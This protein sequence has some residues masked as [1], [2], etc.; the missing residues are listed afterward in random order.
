MHEISV[1]AHRRLSQTGL[2]QTTL[3]TLV[4]HQNIAHSMSDILTQHSPLFIKSYG[5]ATEST[6]EFRGTS[7]S[8]TQVLW[9][10]LRINSPMLGTVDF[11]TIPAFFIDQANL[12]HGASSLTLTGG[13]LGGAV[14][15]STQPTD[16]AGLGLQYIQGVGSFKT[17]D[18]FMR[19]TYGARRW[20]SSTRI[21][22]ATSR[23]DFRYTNYDKKVDVRDADGSIIRSYHP[24][25]RNRSG[26]FHDLH[27]LQDFFYHPAAGGTLAASFWYTH[28]LR[29]LPF[30]SVDYRDDADFT[31]EQLQNAIRSALS[32]QRAFGPRWSVNTRAGYT[33]QD[34]AYDYF[35]T[36]PSATA[37]PSP[38]LGG[39]SAESSNAA[40][41]NVI[42]AS[43]SYSQQG[44]LQA[45]ADYMPAADW[46][47][48]A[49]LGFAYNHVRSHDRSPF[50]IGDNYNRGRLETAL[51]LS[52]KYRPTPRLALST[53]LREELY[54]RDLVP[55]IPAFFGEYKLIERRARG[56]EKRGRMRG[57]NFSS[58]IFKTS[59]ARN[60][61]YPTM[62]DLYFRPG[63]N[64][65]LKP[66][67]GFT[68]D[69]GLEFSYRNSIP[70][71]SNS[72]QTSWE[73]P[74][75]TFS[76]HANLS[77]FDSYITD[78]IQWTPN[79]KG[80]WQPSNLKRVHN[81]GT[82]LTL[83]ATLQLPRQWTLALNTNYAYT[84]SINRSRELDA[85]DTS[86]GKQL[87]YVPR[88]SAN[89]SARLGWRTWMLTYQWHAYSERFTTTSNDVSRI[90]GRLK[91]YYMS[92]LTLERQFRWRRC[93]T[94]LKGVVYNLLGSEYV[95]VLSRPMAGRHFELFLEVKY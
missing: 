53:I 51:S 77:V 63:G 29:G 61:R 3:D 41:K 40:E 84:P 47:L 85:A 21:A 94:S 43:Q 27:A 59:V 15:L 34:I 60:Y 72:A 70:R 64:P 50:H 20:Q 1:T 93:Q 74:D 91:P 33:Y 79:A 86:Y 46:L 7:P 2:Q 5:R 14:D 78:W 30:L 82:E 56:E 35:T 66:E 38:A 10:G 39:S 62:D 90:T 6:A 54:G 4:L 11:S 52:A 9:N 68:Y 57:G 31:N 67:R 16:V 25:E 13:G 55:L 88:H 28:S 26:Y 80:Y 83:D 58:L 71:P 89:L 76:L 73:G 48:T 92:D 65:D 69:G 32:Y 12:L 23:N 22:Y 18:Q 81:Y 75:P 49:D 42:T 17:F 44:F 19:M 37:S 45:K 95:T 87:V 36:R 8:H 24:T